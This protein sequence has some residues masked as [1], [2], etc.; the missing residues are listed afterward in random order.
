MIC[1]F[2]VTFVA[3]EEA[4]RAEEARKAAEAKKVMRQANLNP[5]RLGKL[6]AYMRN[7]KEGW[8]LLIMLTAVCRWALCLQD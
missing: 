2:M 3:Q 8:V 6:S 7:S 5:K 4:A 1:S